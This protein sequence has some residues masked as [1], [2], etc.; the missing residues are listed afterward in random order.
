MSEDINDR[1]LRLERTVL[2]LEEE[3]L[4]AQKALDKA[5]RARASEAELQDCLRFVRQ[6]VHQAHHEGQIESCGKSTCMA[7]TVA[8]EPPR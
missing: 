6:A 7:I 3:L 5:R 2:R 1:L 8:L 4:R